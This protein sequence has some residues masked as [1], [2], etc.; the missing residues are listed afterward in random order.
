MSLGWGE[1]FSDMP[2]LCVETCSLTGMVLSFFEVEYR[3]G[4][5][6]HELRIV[7]R[8]SCIPDKLCNSKN[9]REVYAV[10]LIILYRMRCPLFLQSHR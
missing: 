1:C 5:S 7:S 2:V 10:S 6:Y 8:L 3:V 9:G 4:E